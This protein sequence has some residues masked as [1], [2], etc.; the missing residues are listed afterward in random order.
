M[1]MLRLATMPDPLL[2]AMRPGGGPLVESYFLK[3]NAPDRR[4]A[5]WIKHTFLVPCG[6]TRALASAWAIHFD[7]ESNT[8][9][10]FKETWPIGA[11]TWDP[12]RLHLHFGDCVLEEGRARGRLRDDSGSI[13]W[14]LEFTDPGPPIV[15]LRPLLF[16]TPVPRLKVLSPMPNAAFTGRFTIDGNE[17][18]TDGWKGMLGHNW[19]SRHNQLYAWAH[20]NQ[21]DD[22]PETVF[23]A[24]CSKIEI[25]GFETPLLTTLTLRHQGHHYDLNNSLSLRNRRSDLSYYRWFF[26]VAEPPV[27]VEGVVQCARDEMVGL[28]YDNPDGS[29]TYCLNTKIAH[30]RLFLYE[31]GCDDVVLSSRSAAFEIGTADPHHGVRMAV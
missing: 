7:G 30:L 15:M 26:S 1:R 14:D 5:I 11:V 17:R 8:R 13:A 21:F 6:S 16:H 23:E 3:A 18:S 4:E 10:A 28:Y 31:E 19:G 20:C 9:R 2:P 22:A 24:G 27:R 25:A 29:M 12:D